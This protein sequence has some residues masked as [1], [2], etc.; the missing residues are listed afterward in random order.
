M[1]SSQS[2][3]KANDSIKD[4]QIEGMSIGDSALDYFTKSDII[5]NSKDFYKNKKFTIVQNDFY[6]F[7]KLYDAVDYHFK[8]GDKNYKFQG[9]SGV[10]SYRNN[11]KDCYPKIDEISL[12]IDSNF[13]YVKKYEKDTFK[14]QGDNT[15]K[16]IVTEVTYKLHDGYIVILCYDYSKEHGGQDH[17]SVSI[18][19]AELNKWFINEAYK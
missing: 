12:S 19:T 6:D 3:T 8:S 14:H 15:G 2:L 9:L 17:L 10:L 4:F 16:S 11:I 5:N 13:S 18:D 1:L 7:F